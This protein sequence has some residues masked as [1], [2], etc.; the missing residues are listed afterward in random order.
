VG[1]KYYML[2]FGVMVE[3]KE[4]RG[5]KA[6]VLLHGKEIETPIKNLRKKV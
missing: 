2:P 3:V 1:E 5:K 4:V 6:I